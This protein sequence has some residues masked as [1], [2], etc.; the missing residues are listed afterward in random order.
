[1]NSGIAGKGPPPGYAPPPPQVIQTLRQA[2]GLHQQGQLSQAEALYRDV[3]KMQPDNADALHFLG[4]LQSQQGRREAGL[5]L[6]DRAVAVNP[7]S[8]AAFY[9]RAGILR[10]MKRLEEALE[11]YDRALAL[12]ADHHAALNN[13]GA[14]LH[15]LKRY[16]EAVQSFDRA[17]AMKPD[18]AD[19][20]S[21]RAISLVEL[22]RLD[23]ALE[24]FRRSLEIAGDNPTAQ[25][26]RGNALSGLGQL[27]EALSAYDAAL[28]LMPYD[29]RILTNRGTVLV[30][31]NR[32][33][34]A[35]DSFNRAVIADPQDAEA[36][37]SR[38]DAL[39]HLRRASEALA[40]YD[41]ALASR[42][43]YAEALYG[44]AHALSEL[45]RDD[46][47]IAAYRVLLG[48][49]PDHPY[50]PG[51]L[52]HTKQTACDW[53]GRAA[54]VADIVQG[55]RAGRRMASPLAFVAVSDSEQDNAQCAR[56]LIEDKFKASA[57]PLWRGERYRHDRTRLV[58]LSCDFGAHAVATQIAGVFERHD[59][60]RFE[61]I[62]MSYGQNDQSEM[63]A[64][65]ERAFDRFIDIQGKSDG[66]GASQI[67]GLE[68]DI[69]IDL[70]G[71]TARC[72]PGILAL[73]PAGLQVQFLGFAGTLG[74]DYVDYV[75]ADSVVIPEADHKHYAEKVACL[76][77]S[78]MPT[79]CGRAIAARPSRAEAG[80]PETGFVFC[81]FNNSYKFSPDVF[82]IWMRLLKAAENSVLWLP[83]M[84]DTARRNLLREA[85]TRGISSERLV[86]A[87]YVASGAEHLA[88]LSLADLFLDTRPYNAHSSATDALW[89]GVPVL[90][91]PGDTF[92]GRVGASVLK[93]CGL[94]ELVAESSV[95]YE[96]IALQL[97]RNPDA[98]SELKA[99]LTGKLATCAL[100]DTAGFTR[101]LE[102]AYATMYESHRRGREAQSFTISQMQS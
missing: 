26:G 62:A 52:L 1:M 87:P 64:R 98:L 33:E 54:I 80:L 32:Y 22:G 99:K 11:S 16:S 3:L 55:V 96:A 79:D 17:I 15:D 39:I 69:V 70:T 61:T 23:E 10:D 68:A 29:A 40:S 43:G 9:N 72:R 73:R 44:R 41:Q 71:L 67:R 48:T 20:F 56:I 78:Y 65:L 46:E 2:W 8:A 94:P 63:R 95:S 81:A 45:K 90:T 49:R 34:Q 14:V 35:V 37:K 47:S 28:S 5:S 50:G 30:R 77:N 92:A 59:R 21:N 100:F 89:A 86:F 12:K 83:K 24:S 51:M 57:E 74:A 93:A 38:G 76:P 7:R 102:A 36:C 25:F 4:V 60:T 53:Q 6:I 66:E 18:S 75:I 58:Y 31:L 88:R 91:Q 13:R 42:P 85:E 27:E 84:N 19:A 101:H 82:D 97:A